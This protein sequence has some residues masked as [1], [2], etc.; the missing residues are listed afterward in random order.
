MV[1]KSTNVV[2]KQ[3]V[4][5]LGDLLLVG[6]IQSA[7]KRDPNI[8]SALP[9]RTI[10]YPDLPNTLQVHWPDFDDM[11][12][13]FALQNAVS[14]TTGH[15]GNVQQFCAIDHVVICETI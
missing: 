1:Q 3:W 14:S 12:H 11:S 2:N 5:Q 15:S 8:Q 9:A 4:E 6:K 7:L 13:F 10:L